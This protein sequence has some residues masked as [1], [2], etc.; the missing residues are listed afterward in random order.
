M[1]VTVLTGGTSAERDVALASAVQVV[2]ALRSR[3]HQVSVVDTARGY[4][5]E[6]DEAT[7]VPSKVGVAPPSTARLE[8]L[9]RGVLVGSL[10]Q[11]PAIKGADVLFLALHGG[12]GE[13]GTIQSVLEVIGVPYTGSR[14][15]GSALAM[16]R[17]SRRSS[18][19]RRGCRSP[20]GSWCRRA[21]RSRP[22][23]HSPSS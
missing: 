19:K 10:S 8:E 17:T 18:S 16:D 15:L 23:S 13:D 9:Q 21:A 14:A 11:I 7:L 4:I 20:S 5:A 12:A 3:G 2:A 1:R 6:A 22:R